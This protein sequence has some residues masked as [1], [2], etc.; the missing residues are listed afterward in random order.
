MK[1]EKQIRL[2]ELADAIQDRLY[3][4]HLDTELEKLLNKIYGHLAK[5]SRDKSEQ[6]SCGYSEGYGIGYER[7]VQKGY[8]EGKLFVAAIKKDPLA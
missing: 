3:V 2:G 7:G 6:Y 8:E 4:E 5:S 1:T